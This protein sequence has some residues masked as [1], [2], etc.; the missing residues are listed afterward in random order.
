[1]R[2]APLVSVF[3]L[4]LLLAVIAGALVLQHRAERI[5]LPKTVTLYMEQRGEILPLKFDELICGSVFAVMSPKSDIKAL[6]AAACAASSSALYLMQHKTPLQYLGADLSDS[7][8][9]YLPPEEVEA[10]YGASAERYRKKVEEAVKRGTAYAVCFDGEPI[11]APVCEIS[12]GKTDCSEDILGKALP[13]LLPAE[14]EADASAFGYQSTA[15]LAPEQIYKALSGHF[16]KAFLSPDAETWFCDP[17]YSESGTLLEISY[18][19]QKVTG[20]ELKE[21]LGLR[22]AAITLE[23]GEERWLFTCRGCG[24]NLG[25][26]LYTANEMAKQGK[27]AAEIL[28]HAYPGSALKETAPE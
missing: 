20:A 24:D 4:L 15:E 16:P 17:V 3:A 6:E 10:L 11:Y 8:L 13:C 2:K 5:E 12:S 9:A 19:G 1:M 7:A 26:S 28:L 18:G 25:M 22:S 14:M 21:L 27:T 23:Y